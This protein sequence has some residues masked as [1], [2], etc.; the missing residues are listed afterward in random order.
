MVDLA[1]LWRGAAGLTVVALRSFLGT[2]LVVSVAGAFLA[3]ASAYLLRQHPLYA[4]IAAVLAVAEAVIA[5]ILLGGK[6][7]MV[8]ALVH[9]LRSLQ[10]GQT[11][12]RLVFTRLLGVAESQESGSR[13]GALVL[14][15]ERLPLAQ[16]ESRLTAAVNHLLAAP[17][18]EGGWFRRRV[19]GLL[20]KT[21]KR[22]TLAR[23]REEGDRF[24]GVDLGKVQADLETRADGMLLRG[25]RGGLKLWTVLVVIGLPAVVFAQTYLLLVLLKTK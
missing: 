4:S 19:R 9:G 21:V 1:S 18:G 13:N 10:L 15:A 20:L 2:F 7:A 11:A 3:A 6:R 17:A 8:M 5:G 14:A 24:G 12:V 25:V 16:A 22:F 23:F